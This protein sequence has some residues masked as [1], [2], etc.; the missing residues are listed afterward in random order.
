MARFNE[1]L[2][3]AKFKGLETFMF[4][5]EQY[6]TDPKKPINQPA[7]QEEVKNEIDTDYMEKY[8]LQ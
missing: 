7:K 8:N 5:G 1:A 2:E 3:T 6:I 4:D